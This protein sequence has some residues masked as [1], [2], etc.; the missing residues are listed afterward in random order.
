MATKQAA[1]RNGHVLGARSVHCH[2]VGLEKMVKCCDGALSLLLLPE[3]HLFASGISMGVRGVVRP[4]GM[5]KT[6]RDPILPVDLPL[7]LFRHRAYSVALACKR[8]EARRRTGERTDDERLRADR[9]CDTRQ[10]QDTKARERSGCSFMTCLYISSRRMPS[11][12]WVP[13]SLSRLPFY[14]HRRRRSFAERALPLA[15]LWRALLYVDSFGVERRGFERVRPEEDSFDLLSGHAGYQRLWQ[16][17]LPLSIVG[18]NIPNMCTFAITFHALNPLAL[19]VSRMFVA[20]VGTVI[21]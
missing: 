19:K 14:C 18:N 4:G 1:T 20:L 2:A 16:V 21:R 6:S 8:T 9:M 15:V 3:S 10:A 13:P 7:V 5:A 17:I 11:F 12:T